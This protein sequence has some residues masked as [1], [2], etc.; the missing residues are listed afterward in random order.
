VATQKGRKTLDHELLKAN[1]IKSFDDFDVKIIDDVLASSKK[2]GQP[3][4]RF[5]FGRI[6]GF[7]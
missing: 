1:L 7:S 5:Q 4:E 6:N 3:F 2:E